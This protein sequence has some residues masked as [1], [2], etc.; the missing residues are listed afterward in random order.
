MQL[1][2]FGLVL[3][4]DQWIK[5]SVSSAATLNKGVA[6]GIGR[7][8]GG[9]VL[10]VLVGFGL[11]I[12]LWQLYRSQLRTSWSRYGW[13]LIF[14]G[15]VSNLADRVRFGAVVDPIHLASWFPD[16]NLADVSLFVG[17]C[18]IGIELFRSS[19]SHD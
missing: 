9:V 11:L 4:V 7:E 18:C 1:L 2:L 8:G 6:F 3:V 10:L 15:A 14:A 5:G 16:L 17:V 19:A 13:A 12:F